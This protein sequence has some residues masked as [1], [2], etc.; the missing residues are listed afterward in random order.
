MPSF[1][2]SF[3]QIVL[4]SLFLFLCVSRGAETHTAAEQHVAI[5]EQRQELFGYVLTSSLSLFC[6]SAHWRPGVSNAAQGTQAP[7]G[8]DVCDSVTGD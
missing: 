2:D 6:I 3:V 8:T 4:T 5:S 7:A 1:L